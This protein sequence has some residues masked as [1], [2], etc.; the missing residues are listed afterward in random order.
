MIIYFSGN[1]L[2]PQIKQNIKKFKPYHNYFEIKHK[3]WIYFHL[4]LTKLA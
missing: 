1:K 4:N 3:L 2:Y